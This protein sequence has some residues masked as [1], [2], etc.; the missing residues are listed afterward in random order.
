M[1]TLVCRICFIV[2]L[3]ILLNKYDLYIIAIPIFLS[4][5]SIQSLELCLISANLKEVEI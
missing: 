2:Q 1:L 3:N 4:F 5:N